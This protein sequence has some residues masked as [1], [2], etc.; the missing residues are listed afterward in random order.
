[1]RGPMEFVGVALY[2]DPRTT[3]LRRAWELFGE[4]ADE[5]SISRVDRDIYGLQV[6]HPRFPEQFE[7]T[8]VAGLLREPGMPLPIRMISK[9]LPECT[10]AVQI[11]NGGV[12]GIDEALAYLYRDYIPGNGY[13]VGLPIDLERYC[14]VQNHDR[15]PDQIEVWVPIR[16]A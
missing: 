2:G 11:V 9:S 8:Y 6:Y 1:M 10:Y 14:N 16:Q 5:A 12:A 3:A 13:Q 4:Y 7:L 15:C